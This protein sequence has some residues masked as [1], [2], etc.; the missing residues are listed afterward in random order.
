MKQILT[1]LLIFNWLTSFSQEYVTNYPTVKYSNCSYCKIAKVIVNQ[2]NTKV[3]IEVTGQKGMN[4]WVSFSSWTV[5]L[6]Y[7][8]DDGLSDLRNYDLNIPSAPYTSD[9]NLIALWKQVVEKKRT[10]QA[11]AIKY[12]GSNMIKNLGNDKLDTRY[13]IKSKDA[14]IFS[15]WLTFDKLPPGVEEIVIIELI[16][17][18]FEWS[19]IKIKNP[20][21]TP[22]SE[23]D[24]V[25]LKIDWEKNGITPL[26][27]IYENTIKDDNSPKYRLALKYD[28]TNEQYIL[29]YLSGADNNVWKTGDIKAY[30]FK[31]ASPNIFKVKWYMGNK[32]L[33]EDLYIS[34][35]QGLMKIIWTNGSPE[36]LYLKLY[37]TTEVDFATGNTGKSSGTGFALSSDGYI[38]TNY[39]VIEGAK[40]IKVKGI[41][42]NFS[43]S[44]N[45]I[46][47]VSDKN[48]DIAIIKIEDPDFTNLGIP[49]YQI[50]KDLSEVGTS[51]YALGFPLRTTMGDEVKLTNGII[52]S[53]TGFQGD[54]T[55]YQ[56]S[57]PV[58]P[59]NS[60]GPLFNEKGNVIGI[61]NAKHIGA[62]NASYAIKAS[63]L[64]NLF[65]VMSV[66]PALPK[67][68]SIST[69]S[70]SEQV[71]YVKEFVYVIEVN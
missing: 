56:I 69:K 44:Y 62:E 32:T 34:F 49:P 36:Q 2:T 48:N 51:V 46:I 37:P 20:D 45:A 66:T 53:K 10:M 6:P 26:E 1:F 18:G 19:G 21:T 17:N 11:E 38:V 43:K 25:S 29:I 60:G 13:N 40:T 23:W 42:G 64:F 12:L 7:N 58:Q 63:Y 9:A 16:E 27:G 8:S 55:T 39:H 30:I 57:V 68:N 50:D 41:K 61:I 52:S 65:Q 14:Q 35:E 3:L 59:G 33:S 54:I 67:E 5:L 22:K 28:K 15:F 71:K 4:P 70:L 47:V 31:T 24:E